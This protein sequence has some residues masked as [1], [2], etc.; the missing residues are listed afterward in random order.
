VI[1]DLVHAWPRYDECVEETRKTLSLLTNLT[2]KEGEE[3][4]AETSL[5]VKL[6]RRLALALLYEVYRWVLHWSSSR[7]M[8][9]DCAPKVSDAIIISLDNY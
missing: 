3:S 7:S 2:G 5:R 9:R 8:I 4:H 6:W 1:P